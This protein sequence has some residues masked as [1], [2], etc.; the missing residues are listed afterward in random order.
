MNDGIIKYKPNTADF[1]VKCD[2]NLRTTPPCNIV[3]ITPEQKY[4]LNKYL[5]LHLF[6][7]KL[8]GC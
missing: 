3:I 4:L 7:A 8:T 1:C 6:W 5:R 2:G